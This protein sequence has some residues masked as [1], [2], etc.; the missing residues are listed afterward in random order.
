M[1]FQKIAHLQDLQ[2]FG[3]SP[4]GG[5]VPL[6]FPPSLRVTA[7]HHSP[8]HDVQRKGSEWKGH[9]RSHNDFVGFLLA[10]FYVK[11]DGWTRSGLWCLL[12]FSVHTFD[13][14]EFCFT[15]SDDNV[16]CLAA[17]CFRSSRFRLSDIGFS[18]VSTGT[19]RGLVCFWSNHAQKNY[20]QVTSLVLKNATLRRTSSPTFWISGM[21]N[22]REEFGKPPNV[23]GTP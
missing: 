21:S 16:S 20:S 23:L 2:I 17:S 6:P 9:D 8:Q 1:I 18:K 15:Y 5:V 3:P 14:L 10:G 22:L 11:V 12:S 19:W 4:S 7:P 13:G